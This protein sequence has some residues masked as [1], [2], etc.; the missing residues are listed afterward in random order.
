MQMNVRGTPLYGIE[1]RPPG[2]VVYQSYNRLLLRKRSI[3]S[4]AH[5]QVAVLCAIISA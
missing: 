4:I 2:Q 5:N 1:Q 3:G